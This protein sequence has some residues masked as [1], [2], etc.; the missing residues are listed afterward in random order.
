MEIPHLTKI[1]GIYHIG[2]TNLL[3]R[4]REDLP[5]IV[6]TLPVR[7][8]EIGRDGHQEDVGI[9]QGFRSVRSGW[10]AELLCPFDGYIYTMYADNQR[11]VSTGR[12]V[13]GIAL[14]RSEI[15]IEVS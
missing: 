7:I 13:R 9:L 14:H 11:A 15:V 5:S 1:R 4:L 6:D 3:H 10:I 8:V 2:L 12:K